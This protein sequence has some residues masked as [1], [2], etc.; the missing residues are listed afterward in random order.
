MPAG[1]ISDVANADRTAP[2]GRVLF[3]RT[4][5]GTWFLTAVITYVF[6]VGCTV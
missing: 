3:G 1:A 6:V 5:V 2:M 4:V